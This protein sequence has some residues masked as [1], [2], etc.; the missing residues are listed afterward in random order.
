MQSGSCSTELSG[1]ACLHHIGTAKPE[2]RKKV[3][4]NSTQFASLEIGD[5]YNPTIRSAFHPLPSA[6]SFPWT[7]LAITPLE[8][9]L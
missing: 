2:A 1:I 8:R 7:F 5:K 3:P 6:K 4:I 9:R